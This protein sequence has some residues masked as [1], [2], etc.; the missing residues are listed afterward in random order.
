[1][2]YVNPIHCTRDYLNQSLFVD[3]CALRSAFIGA[4]IVP[5]GTTCDLFPDNTLMTT[6]ALYGH[7]IAPFKSILVPSLCL[8]D[9]HGR[10]SLFTFPILECK[11][12][13]FRPTRYGVAISSRRIE[14]H[15]QHTQDRL[16]RQQPYLGRLG[17]RLGDAAKRT[18]PTSVGSACST[19]DRTFLDETYPRAIQCACKP[20]SRP[21]SQSHR[22][23]V[24]LPPSPGS[25]VQT[26][27]GRTYD[28]PPTKCM[29]LVIIY[30]VLLTLTAHRNYL[31]F[32]SPISKA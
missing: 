27:S 17:R 19:D 3:R 5:N 10:L 25:E 1:M 2:E 9:W 22:H 32:H 8:L 13:K 28:G 26:A 21:A 24:L 16:R 31:H 20:G 12:T 11:C 4:R 23:K 7:A 14:T 6:W 15:C 18:R 29:S 30:F